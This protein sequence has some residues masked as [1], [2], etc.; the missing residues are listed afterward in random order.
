MGYQRRV[1]GERGLGDAPS[2]D[3]DPVVR[4]RP[5]AQAPVHLFVRDDHPGAELRAPVNG[6]HPA[7]GRQDRVGVVEFAAA[8]RGIVRR[9]QQFFECSPAHRVGSM[10]EGLPFLCVPPAF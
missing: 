4:K 5:G 6:R 7:Q 1:A 2:V 8:E 9:A 3:L 10:Q